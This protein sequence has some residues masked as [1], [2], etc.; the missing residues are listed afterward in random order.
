MKISPEM[1]Q[2]TVLLQNA[3]DM[4]LHSKNISEYG[5]ATQYQSDIKMVWIFAGIAFFILLIAC[6]NFI[7]LSTANAATRAKEIGIRKPLDQ[8]DGH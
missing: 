7:N 2:S 8:I 4:H 5:M 1:M 6:I 3:L